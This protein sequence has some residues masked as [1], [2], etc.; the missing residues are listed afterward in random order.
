MASSI[1]I[2][3]VQLPGREERIADFAFTS[4]AH[5]VKTLSA[6]LTPYMDRPFAFYGHSM[7]TLIAFELARELRRQNRSGPVHLFVSGRCAPHITDPDPPLH[8]LS[9]TE[10]IDGVRRYNGTSEEILQNKQLMDLLLP[11]LRADFELCETYSC[12]DEVPLD[13]AISAYAGHHE[14]ASELLDDWGHQTS[15]QFETMILP[16]D[17]FFLNMER[18]RFVDA[19]SS[20]LLD[21]LGESSMSY[22][23]TTMEYQV[24]D[25]TGDL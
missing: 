1:E 14:I 24:I 7:G 23:S 25:E 18:A 13:C 4:L 12:R 2:C 15:G 6:V 8:Q 5:L 9:D 10:F 19:I 11:L 17:H 21:Y 20:R 3:P 16:G 22:K